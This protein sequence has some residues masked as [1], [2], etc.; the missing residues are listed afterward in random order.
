MRLVHPPLCICPR[1]ECAAGV[2]CG[3]QIRL[4]ARVLVR[5]EHGRSD[6]RR[7]RRL[8]PHRPCAGLAFPLTERQVAAIAV[9]VA[10]LDGD[11]AVK[12]G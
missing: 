3:I 10:T 6:G 5:L 7:A 9:D 4:F 1:T 8:N 12:K 2:Q 11:S